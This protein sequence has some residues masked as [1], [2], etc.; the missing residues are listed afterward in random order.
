M[1]L[2]ENFSKQMAAAYDANVVAALKDAAKID[3]DVAIACA[4]KIKSKNLSLDL[5][6]GLASD[7]MG[8]I[9]GVL[10]EKAPGG[11]MYG[12]VDIPRSLSLICD[13]ELPSIPNRHIPL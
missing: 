13:T 8:S 3:D 4:T 9:T 5:L 6:K 12:T 10:A 11:D 7:D 2:G 1:N